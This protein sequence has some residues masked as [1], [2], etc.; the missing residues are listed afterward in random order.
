MRPLLQLIVLF[1]L[2]APA[3]ISSA[4]E[5]EYQVKAAML[6]NFAKFVEWPADAFGSEGRI[7]FCIAGKSPITGTIQQMQG[8]QIK[9]RT[10][11]IRPIGRPNDVNECQILFIP[12]SENAHISAYLQQAGH[13]S[14]LTVSDQERFTTNGGM[15]GFYDEESRVRFEVSQEN[16]QKRRLKI[17]SDLLNLARRIR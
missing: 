6:Y 17:S 13:F 9:G 15:I 1:L 3:S 16:A 14:I 10:V 2:L 8:K 4:A 7:A 5:S 12:K 11:T